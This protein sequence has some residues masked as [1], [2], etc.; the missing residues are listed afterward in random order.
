[1]HLSVKAMPWMTAFFLVSTPLFGNDEHQSKSCTTNVCNPVKCCTPQVP[2]EPLKCVY[3]APAEIDVGC[4]G[5]IDV[6]GSASFLY[7]QPSQDNMDIGF[8][9]QNVAALIGIPTPSLPEASIRGNFIDMDFSYHPG[10]KV[11]LGMNLQKDDW[12]GYAEYTR[13][14]GTSSTS[15]NGPSVG[16]NSAGPIPAIFSTFGNQALL[17]L[18]S[19]LYNT[20]S[21]RYRNN[22]DFLDAEIGRTY[23]VGKSLIFRPAW[24]ARAAWILQ[25]IHVQYKNIQTVGSRDAVFLIN[26]QPSIFDVFQ[27]SHSWAVGPRMG[28][29][30][31]WM[32]GWGFRF[33]GRGYGDLLYTQYAVRDK[34]ILVLTSPS[35]RPTPAAIPGVPVSVTTRDKPTGLRAHL[36]L[37]LGLGW[38]RYFDCNKWHVDLSA[39][40]GWQIFFGQNMFR[41]YKS[42]EMVAFST[43]PHGNLYVQG[44]TLTARVDF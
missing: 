20:V 33:N 26:S 7:W 18:G 8:V 2:Q 9:D 24:G 23:Y 31:D 43:L 6:F 39:S 29:D 40:Y 32:I 42:T 22:L 14:H 16:S 17:F 30:M 35:I 3:N 19:V 28:L 41:H 34:S 37:E 5:D 25:N 38:G 12:D 44:L 10:F 4:K 21:A 1:M 27:N 15:S 13:V 36:D 11:G